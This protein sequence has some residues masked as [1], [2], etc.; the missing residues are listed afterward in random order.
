MLFSLSPTVTDLTQ[1]FKSAEKFTGE[2]LWLWDVR[3]V[4]PLPT[5]SAAQKDH[6][7]GECPTHKKNGGCSTG[8]VDHIAWRARC[9]VT[10]DQCVCSGQ[11]GSG[12][13]SSVFG[14][15]LPSL[16]D[17]NKKRIG[18]AWKIHGVFDD[19]FGGTQSSWADLACTTPSQVITNSDIKR[20]AWDWI[21]FGKANATKIWGAIEDWDTSLVTSMFALFR[22]SRVGPKAQEWPGADLTKWDTGNVDSFNQMFEGNSKFNGNVSTFQ[23]QKA[24]HLSEMFRGCAS[25]NGGLGTWDVSKVVNT[26]SMFRDASK[27]VSVKITRHP[28]TPTQH[29]TP[30]PCHLAMLRPTHAP[31]TVANSFPLISHLSHYLQQVGTGLSKWKTGSLK[32][33]ENMFEDA[34]LFNGD[35]SSFNT[36]GEVL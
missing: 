16:S 5:C 35:V 27:F 30:K 1:A 33:M 11:E 3:A 4:K 36:E 21:N 20:A 24:T 6:S 31:K 26:Y 29:V 2:D 17:C 25:F 7:D 23:I 8:N 10:C 18:S 28:P 22:T 15:S 14:G 13:F 32:S 34:R 9:P 12:G 19:T